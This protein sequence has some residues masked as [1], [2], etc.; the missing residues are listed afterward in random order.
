MI[1][2]LLEDAVATPLRAAGFP[3]RLGAKDGMR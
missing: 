2:R 3:A 1:V